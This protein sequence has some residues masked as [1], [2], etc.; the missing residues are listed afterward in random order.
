MTDDFDPRDYPPV[1]DAAQV[2][3]LLRFNLDYVR[4]LSRAG[5]IPARRLPGGRK[6]IYLKDEIL[7]WVRAQPSVG[8][9]P[10]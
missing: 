5:V 2:A 10:E 8:A 7:D 3:A 1:L 6:F 9:D 4:K